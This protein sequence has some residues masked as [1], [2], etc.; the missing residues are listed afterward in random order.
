MNE[1]FKPACAQPNI[2]ILWIA[3]SDSSETHPSSENEEEENFQ[4]GPANSQQL[5][6][7][8]SPSINDPV[9][10]KKAYMAE[11]TIQ[12]SDGKGTRLPLE[13]SNLY[14]GLCQMEENSQKTVVI[15]VGTV[16]IFIVPV[17]WLFGYKDHSS[18]FITEHFVSAKHIYKTVDIH[19]NAQ[20]H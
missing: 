17:V 10:L 3:S 4:Q 12:I 5:G 6:C 20:C 11:H 2:R 9:E 19:E 8:I 18:T 16:T 13:P 15:F 1:K 7:L 14:I